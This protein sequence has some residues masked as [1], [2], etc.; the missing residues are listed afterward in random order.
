MLWT[1]NPEMLR[2]LHSERVRQVREGLV[3]KPHLRLVGME[4]EAEATTV[5]P[6][7]I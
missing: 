4:A 6:A 1:N 3:S 2:V 5:D 7:Q